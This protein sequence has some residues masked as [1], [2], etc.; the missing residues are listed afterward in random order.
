MILVYICGCV[1]VTH[2]VC[3][4]IREGVIGVCIC[5]CVSATHGVCIEVREGVGT[6]LL[7]SE[8][9]GH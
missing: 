1:S 8:A 9:Q 5:G 2:G 6:L 7:L 4:E 3:M